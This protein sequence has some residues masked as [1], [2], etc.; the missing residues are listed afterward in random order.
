MTHTLDQLFQ[1]IQSRKQSNEETSWT[2]QLLRAG[3]HFITRKILE[4]AR[5]V[6]VEAMAKDR[7]KLIAESAD[8]LYHLYVLWAD[9]NISPADV[10]KELQRREGISGIVEK[11]NRDT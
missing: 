3:T 11:Q 1:T 5:E 8:L 7:E 2:A 9:S 6:S 10:Y 4:E